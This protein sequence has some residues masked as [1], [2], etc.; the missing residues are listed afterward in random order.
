LY[1]QSYSPYAGPQA[2]AVEERC[3]LATARI[4]GLI[5]FVLSKTVTVRPSLPEPKG[6]FRNFRFFIGKRATIL[7][8]KGLAF[9]PERSV[10]DSRKGF[11]P[12]FNLALKRAQGSAA[13]Y[14]A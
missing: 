7:L 3:S 1:R 6:G 2:R 14:V 8:Q 4:G 13:S 11:S 9:R 5:G 10:T 12:G